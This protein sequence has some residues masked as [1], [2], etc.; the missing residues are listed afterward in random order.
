MDDRDTRWI[1]RY[2]NYTKALLQL[3][4]FVDKGKYLN[5]LEEQGMIKT[6]EYTYELAWNTIKDFYE[7]QGESDIQG[8][9]DSFQLAFKRG[10]IQNGEIWMEMLKDRNRTSHSY[11]EKTATEISNSIL[12]SYYFL[13]K[14]LHRTLEELINRRDNFLKESK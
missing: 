8:S 6:F 12:Q 4:K 7:S 3:Q 11:N 9:R 2:G 10:L 5:E 13:F 14:T 1:Q